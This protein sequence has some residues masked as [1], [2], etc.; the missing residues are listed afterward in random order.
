MACIKINSTWFRT[1]VQRPSSGWIMWL[2]LRW[3]DTTQDNVSVIQA[4]ASGSQGCQ[5]ARQCTLKL[6]IE[7]RSCNHFCRRKEVLH[8]LCVCRLSYPACK[9]VATHYIDCGPFWLY[10]SPHYL[11]NCKISEKIFKIKCPFNFLY[12][13]CLKHV[14]FYKELNG[15]LS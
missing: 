2:T 5:Q 12:N 11:T 6:N 7:A 14:A 1:K 13:F 15:A 9:A 10:P 3:S 8:I 4:G